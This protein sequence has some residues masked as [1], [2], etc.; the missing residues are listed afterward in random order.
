MCHYNTDKIQGRYIAHAHVADIN[1]K[2]QHRKLKTEILSI[3]IDHILMTLAPRRWN[4][5]IKIFRIK[6]FRVRRF[7]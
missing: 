4:E 2:L 5:S 3:A 1:T 6:T 7:A